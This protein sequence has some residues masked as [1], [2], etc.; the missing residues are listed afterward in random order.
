MAPLATSLLNAMRLFILICGLGCLFAACLR[1]PNYPDMPVITLRSVVFGPNIT[2]GSGALDSM[3]VTVHF[4]DGNGDLGLSQQD[5]QA[6][7]FSKYLPRTDSSKFNL[8][9]YNFL[10]TIFAENAQ[11]RFD[12]IPDRRT[13]TGFTDE[14]S[15]YGAFAPTDDMLKGQPIEGT[16]KY[17]V[18]DKLAFFNGGTPTQNRGLI[19]K[20]RRWYVTLSIL[21]RGGNVSNK[22]QSATFIY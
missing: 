12:T 9:Y 22:V 10:L 19:V 16:I 18:S 14:K 3:L 7:P 15:R 20:G 4:T 11:G 6:S 13:R 2:P 1:K 5:R 21:D 8:R 17:K